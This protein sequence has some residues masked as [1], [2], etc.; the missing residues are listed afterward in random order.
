[1]DRLATNRMRCSPAAE[2]TRRGKCR[3]DL[4]G[5]RLYCPPLPEFFGPICAYHFDHIDLVVHEFSY[6]AHNGID[7]VC[8]R[9]GFPEAAVA[10][11]HGDTRTW[12]QDARR[13]DR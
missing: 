8:G 1:A 4:F 2:S 9:L 12:S 7:A 3:V 11:R 13:G 5:G 6:A 10:A